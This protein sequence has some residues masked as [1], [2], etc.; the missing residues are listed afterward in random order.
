MLCCHVF[1]SNFLQHLNSLNINILLALPDIYVNVKKNVLNVEKVNIHAKS[2][3][4][5]LVFNKSYKL[6]L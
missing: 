6:H 4:T 1:T 2:G 5:C 3:F